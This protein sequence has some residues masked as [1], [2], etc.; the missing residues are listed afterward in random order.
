M[1]K[2]ESDFRLAQQCTGL[3]SGA[4]FL[5]AASFDHYRRMMD[6]LQVEARQSPLDYISHQQ[7]GP[8]EGAP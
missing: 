2:G 6:R 4:A 5:K 8:A 1:L 7:H 3:D